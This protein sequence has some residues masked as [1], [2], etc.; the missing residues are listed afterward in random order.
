MLILESYLL[1]ILSRQTLGLFVI[2]SQVMPHLRPNF[3]LLHKPDIP[4]Q[5]LSEKKFS[6]LHISEPNF[7]SFKHL[8]TSP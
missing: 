4:V 1:T 3:C 8:T 2:P 7:W 6:V 5:I